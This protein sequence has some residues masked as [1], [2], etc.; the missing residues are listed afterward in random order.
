MAIVGF[1]VLGDRTSH[2]GTV[3]SGC[4][5]FTVHGKPVAR[6]GDKVFCPRCKTTATIISSS[7]PSI[8]SND[9]PV[10]FDLDKTSCGAI[11]Y[12]SHNKKAGWGSNSENEE[13]A[14]QRE[15]VNSGENSFQEHFNLYDMRTGKPLPRVYYSIKTE[16]GRVFTGETDCE[17]RTDVVWTDSPKPIEIT[18]GEEAKERNDKYH[19][20]TGR[21]EGI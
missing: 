8:F 19:A 21:Y 14:P 3:I 10:A 13:S 4:P 18:I 17:G 6:I 12:S 20:Q 2:G 16:E 5:T 7:H 1:I 11:L 15:Y 9:I